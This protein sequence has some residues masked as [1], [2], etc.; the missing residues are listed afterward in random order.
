MTITKM[1]KMKVS[2]SLRMAGFK[3]VKGY[4]HSMAEVGQ[5]VVWIENKKGV[6][7]A[8]KKESEYVEQIIETKDW[9]E[10]LKFLK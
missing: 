1:P 5:C 3:K 8:G 7:M 4:G 10:I 6:F 2:E 9:A